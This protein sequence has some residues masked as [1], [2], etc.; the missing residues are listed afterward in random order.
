MNKSQNAER[1][2]KCVN[3]TEILYIVLKG[4]K[5]IGIYGLINVVV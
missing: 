4:L 2:E 5:I 1:T 3:E